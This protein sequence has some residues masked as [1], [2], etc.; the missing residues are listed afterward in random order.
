MRT[1][2]SVLNFLA[3]VIPF[4]ILGVLNFL[5]I[6]FIVKYYG[7]NVNGYMQLITQ[8]FSYLALAEAGF[9]TA[10][11]YKLYKPLADDDK[12]KISSI[13][14]GS[15]IIFKRIAVV[16]AIGTIICTFLIP[17]FVN[18]ADLTNMFLMSIF[19]LYSIQYLIEYFVIYPYTSL[20]QANQNQ[21]IFIFY[22]NLIRVTFGLLE[23][24]LLKLGMNLLLIVGINI[25]FTIV[26]IILVKRKITKIYPWLDKNAK[27]DTSAFKMTK[28]VLVHRLSSLVFSKTDPIIL[29][30]FSLG[31]VSIYTAYNYILEFITSIVSKIYDSIRASYCNIVALGKKEDKK[32]FN[33]FLAF[34]FFTACF[35]CVTFHVTA[36]SFVKVV[37]LDSDHVLANNTLLLFSIIMLGRIIINPYYVARDSK[38]LYK[39]T[40]YSTILQAV[41]NIVLSL[42]LVR[43]YQIFG[44]LLATII[45]QYLIL[46]PFN[47]W[48]VYS[49]VFDKHSFRPFFLNILLVAANIG[50]LYFIDN[51]MMNL[52]NLET[53]IGVIIF[54]IVIALINLAE[55][56]IVYYLINND[57]RHLV[58][59]L[60]NKIMKKLRKN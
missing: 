2:K 55:C 16:M 49:K 15:K 25:L 3:D 4:L 22:K 41:C 7:D 59:E 37:W 56:F 11:I 1:K 19:L 40:K 13:V 33:M 23:L 50:T 52:F 8:I 47:I 39:E 58:K 46:I 17:L 34:S 21:H 44:V 5:R 31:F 10:V 48:I 9:G 54:M 30:V 45:S 18:K 29:S 42:I 6:N 24:F 51:M 60:L 36:N 35:A 28:D 38:G 53:A 26:Y 57:F 12:D 20:L 27:P 32:Y 43:K 14:N